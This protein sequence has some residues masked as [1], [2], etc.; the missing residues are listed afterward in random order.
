M[1]KIIKKKINILGVV[2]LLLETSQGHQLKIIDTYENYGQHNMHIFLAQEPQNKY[3]KKWKNIAWRLPNEDEWET[4]EEMY[5]DT[6]AS[7]L[8]KYEYEMNIH[9][10]RL[11]KFK[12]FKKTLDK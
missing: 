3:I 12:N 4:L 1:L 9:F 6:V 11:E 5:I 7:A 2:T 8:A 10:K